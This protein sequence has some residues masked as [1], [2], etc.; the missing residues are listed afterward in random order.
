MP[1]D[2]AGE[3]QVVDEADEVAEEH[4]ADPGDHTNNEREQ[5]YADERE[6]ALRF[7]FDCTPRARTGEEGLLGRQMLIH[8]KPGCRSTGRTLVWPIGSSDQFLL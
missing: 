8:R 4:R 2:R 3:Q 7:A 6:A 1:S 5:R